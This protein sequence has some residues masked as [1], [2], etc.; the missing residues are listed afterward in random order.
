LHDVETSNSAG[1]KSP[2]FMQDITVWK[3]YASPALQIDAPAMFACCKGKPEFSP[4]FSPK[5]QASVASPAGS[6]TTT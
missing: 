4:E 1:E 3:L 6:S 5:I 2:M